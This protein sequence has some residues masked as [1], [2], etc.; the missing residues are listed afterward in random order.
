MR[1]IMSRHALQHGGSGFA[2]AYTFRNCDKTVG[3]RGDVFGI[4][5]LNPGP[6]HPVS[7]FYKIHV[8]AN[9]GNDPGAFLS[10]HERRWDFVA[11]LA[12]ISVNEV[13]PAAA[14]FTTA[15][16]FFGCGTGRST[17]SSASGPPGCFTWIAFMCV[18]AL[19]EHLKIQSL[20][21]F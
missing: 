15:S 20:P 9:S 18:W 11:S 17:S 6:G 19:S 16:L 4:T 14:T 7:Y 5:S 21:G 1:Q 12:L 2:I 3:W 8:V 10:G 13:D